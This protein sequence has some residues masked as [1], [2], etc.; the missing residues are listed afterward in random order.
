MVRKVEER[1]L[2]YNSLVERVGVMWCKRM[3]LRELE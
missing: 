1:A 2:R 3:E